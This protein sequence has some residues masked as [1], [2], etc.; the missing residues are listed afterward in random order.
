M[1]KLAHPLIHE[2]QVP[3]VT[4]SGGEGQIA[5]SKGAWD[6]LPPISIDASALKRSR[7]ITADRR[8]RAFGPFDVLRTKL[9]QALPER[10]WRRVGVTSPTKG[11]G[12][13][14]VSLNL[15]ITLSRYSSFRSVLLDLDMR[16]PVL[17][18]RL[19]VRDAGAMGDFLRGLIPCDEA[20][21]RVGPNSLRI[22]G[23]LAFG[24]NGRP[25][26]FASELLQDS[27][28]QDALLGMEARLSP[29]V[30]LF[31][32]PPVLAQD[33]VL[34]LKPHLDCILM[35]AGGGV[36]TQRDLREAGQRLGEDLPILGVVLNMAEGEEILDYHY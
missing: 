10:G 17:A 21:R 25:E 34:A 27:R 18:K 5:S 26:P 7:I 4:V 1:N 36:T 15:A 3:P 22:G 14:F 9:V 29:H 30:V 23:S 24:L 8:D 20:F 11:C 13:S 32:L 6:G 2:T 35:V 19:G 31:D 33:D 28:A 12:K 16:F